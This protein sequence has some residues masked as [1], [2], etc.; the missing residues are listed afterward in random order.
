MQGLP[1]FVYLLVIPMPATVVI[2][3]IFVLR[4]EHPH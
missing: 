1:A 2:P 4:Q 3:R